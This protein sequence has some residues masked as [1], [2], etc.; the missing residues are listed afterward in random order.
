MVFKHAPQMHMRSA[1]SIFADAPVLIMNVLT[2]RPSAIV[3]ALAM[4]AGLVL[5]GQELGIFFFGV[6]FW[7]VLLSAAVTVAGKRFKQNAGLYEKSRGVRNVLANGIWPLAMSALFYAALIG[8]HTHYELVALL[9][10][11]SAVAAVTADT[12]SSEVGVLDG[13]PV[14]LLNMKKVQKGVSGGVTWLGLAAGLAGSILITLMMLAVLPE[15]HL[16][17]LSNAPGAFAVVV[18][19]GFAGTIVDSVLGYFEEKGIGNKYTS[20]LFGSI[21]G[22]LVCLA[23][24]VAIGI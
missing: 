3:A 21:G 2:L 1:S 19:G 24:A 13:Q 18:L 10:F 5:F 8:G 9:G 23:A 15:M 17:G 16:L 6:M 12:F 11:V 14:M 4:G 7:F 22:S 20:N